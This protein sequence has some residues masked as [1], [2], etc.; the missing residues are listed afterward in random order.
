MSK[1]VREIKREDLVNRGIK[2]ITDTEEEVSL[3]GFL[4]TKEIKE[5]LKTIIEADAEHRK[6]EHTRKIDEGM[7]E[8]GVKRGRLPL[9]KDIQEKILELREEGLTYVSIVEELDKL[10][11][12]ITTRT[13]YKY[14][15][16]K[17]G[18]S[19]DEENEENNK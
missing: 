3:E 10:G 18:G 16:K 5:G 1:V 11:I 7:K 8:K 4:V 2:I 6:R 15:K 17:K 9:S 13:I 14:C 19:S 12:S